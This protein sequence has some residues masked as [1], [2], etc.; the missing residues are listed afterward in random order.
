MTNSIASDHCCRSLPSNLQPRTAIPG[1]AGCPTANDARGAGPSVSLSDGALRP[2]RAAA[3]WRDM[4]LAMM[5][6]SAW[7]LAVSVLLPRE[8]L[9]ALSAVFVAA[10]I[11]S[12]A[13]FAFS[14]V[15]GGMLLHMVDSTV[16][17]VMIMMV[18][19]IAIQSL[20]VALIWRDIDWRKLPIFLLGGI[21]GLPIGVWLLLH[22]DPR[23]FKCVMGALLIAY[24]AYGLS[25]RPVSVRTGNGMCDVLTGCLG[26][27]TGGLAGFPG[28]AVTVWCSMQGWNKRRQRAIYQPYI[29][30]MQILGLLVIRVLHPA[31]TLAGKVAMDFLPFVPVALL[32]AWMGLKIF[33]RLSESHF[34]LAVNVL[35]FVSGVGLM[36]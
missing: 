13:G 27:I 31:A 9:S 21:V 36:V 18:C 11:S 32:G 24:A 16:K 4:T 1:E 23:G 6:G 8:S 34:K 15:A 5:G 7:I 14:A 20:S 22:L 19:S 35:L 3:L 17:V 25:K 29:L 10:T 33:E 2:P 12:V 30:V 26:G 28:A